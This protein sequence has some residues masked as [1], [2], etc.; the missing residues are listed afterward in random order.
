[1]NELETEIIEMYRRKSHLFDKCK[2]FCLSNELPQHGPVSFFN[3]GDDY[4][5]E[6][7]D[8]YKIVFVGKN[9][10][11]DFENLKADCAE[12]EPPFLFKDCRKY[13]ANMFRERQR[14]YWS[15]L[16][17]I[18]DELYPEIKDDS[19]K[20]LSLIA[21]TNLTKCSTSANY[22][23]TTP[24]A[25]TDNCVE[26]LKEELRILKP[27][28]IVFFTGPVYDQ[29]FGRELFDYMFEA[30]KDT[31]KDDRKKIGE[32]SVL[33]WEREFFQGNRKMFVLRTWHPAYP[34]LELSEFAKKVSNWIKMTK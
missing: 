23:D 7:K 10:W 30:K 8:E 9:H 25:L 28:H 4:G 13:G 29:Y 18:T 14:G 33:W 22:K 1:L 15:G 12:F 34:T 19:E 2:E 16:R 6:G 21:I 11:Y 27:K 20:I 17:K 32:L 26:I 3:V 31:A 5:S 24:Y